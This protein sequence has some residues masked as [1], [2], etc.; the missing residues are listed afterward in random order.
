MITIILFI[1]FIIKFYFSEENKNKTAK[2]R[3]N[4]YYELNNDLDNLPTLI[5]DTK[6]IIE[7]KNDYDEFKKKKNKKKV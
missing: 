4:Y 5:D 1:F 7:Y 3:S 6:N 2:L